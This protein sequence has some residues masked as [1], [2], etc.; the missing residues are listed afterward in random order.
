MNELQSDMSYVEL[1]LCQKTLVFFRDKCE[2]LLFFRA[3]SPFKLNELRT[4]APDDLYTRF[5]ARIAKHVWVV[6]ATI[7]QCLQDFCICSVVID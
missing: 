2:V 3:H 5:K 6:F 1:Y 4:T 7:Y